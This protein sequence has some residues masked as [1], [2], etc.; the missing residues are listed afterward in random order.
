MSVRD[1]DGT[2]LEWP[3]G[4]AWSHSALGRFEDCSLLY[5]ETNVKKTYPYTT[6]PAMAAGKVAHKQ[7][8]DYV[9]QGT[10]PPLMLRGIKAF[11]DR[12]CENAVEIVPERDVNL[13]YKLAPCGVFHDDVSYR[14]RI[15]LTVVRHDNEAIIVDY[16]TGRHPNDPPEQI[17][18][19]ALAVLLERPTL[20]AVHGYYLY[21]KH[22]RRPVGAITRADIP[23]LIKGMTPRLN[24]M[25]AARANNNYLPK[26]GTHCKWCPVIT[27]KFNEKR[28]A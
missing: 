11:V 19:Q 4:L 8:E 7:M 3:R 25:A 12:I 24:R 6:S 1:D 14:G 28:S 13:T 17:E 2:V 18:Y 16:K 20:K 22:P 9:Q 26:P 5:A 21:T 23:R 15:D 27:C 10:E